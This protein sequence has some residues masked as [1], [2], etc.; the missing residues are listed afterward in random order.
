MY[1]NTICIFRSII[2]NK[3]KYKFK[4]KNLIIPKSSSADTKTEKLRP[5]YL[6]IL[7]KIR[8]LATRQFKEDLKETTREKIQ[9]AV[10]K[11]KKEKERLKEK[12]RDMKTTEEVTEELKT[13]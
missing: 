8:Q 13:G 7:S 5:E 9:V 12:G 1:N 3:N 11:M 4:K 10:E 2:T 6:Q